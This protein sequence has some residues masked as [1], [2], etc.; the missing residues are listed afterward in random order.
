MEVVSC[1]GCWFR[2]A[3]GRDLRCFA[4]YAAQAPGCSVWSGPCPALASSPPALHKSTGQKAA[5]AFGAFPVRAAQAARSLPGALSP[6]VARLL[7]SESPAPVPARV[8][9]LAATL[10]RMSTIQTLRRSLIRNWR[11]VC[12]A[13]GAAVLGAEPAPLPSHCLQPPAGLGWPA[14]CELFSGLARSI[15]AANGR[16]CVRAG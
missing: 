7:L 16:Q 9:C 5:P 4:L 8:L 15:C 11:P 3:A 2:C 10:P 13:V 14:A 12:S 6:G 1:S